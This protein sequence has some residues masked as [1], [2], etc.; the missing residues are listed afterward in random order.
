MGA[1]LEWCP[2]AQVAGTLEL[3]SV[4]APV[5]PIVPKS[6]HPLDQPVSFSSIGT[7][8]FVT[9]APVAQGWYH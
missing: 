6:C 7:I 9:S 1:D 2:D 4:S 3:T 8:L 5:T